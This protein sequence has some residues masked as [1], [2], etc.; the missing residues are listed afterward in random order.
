MLE[1]EWRLSREAK[2]IHR[3][4]D[5]WRVKRCMNNQSN[6]GASLLKHNF[7]P[8][9]KGSLLSITKTESLW[10]KE[11]LERFLYRYSKPNQDELKIKD[12][13]YWQ[14]APGWP[15]LHHHPPAPCTL[16]RETW[17][18]DLKKLHG[19]S[20]EGSLKYLVGAVL[21][22]SWKGPITRQAFWGG[23]DLEWD[24]GK[25]R[26]KQSFQMNTPESFLSRD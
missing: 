4:M 19:I 26:P 10:P 11:P 24:L 7:P 2:P 14:S 16:L 18:G 6:S 20:L 15:F 17:S 8:W 13:V 22:C 23:W 5:E 1:L 12:Q 25:M 21:R 9:W 3:W